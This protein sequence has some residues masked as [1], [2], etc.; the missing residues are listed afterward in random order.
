MSTETRRPDVSLVIEHETVD[1][2]SAERVR[3]VMRLLGEQLRS[4]P[5]S[6]E[7][8]LPRNSDDAADELLGV[9]VRRFDVAPG[10]HYYEV[11]NAGAREARGRV[12]ALADSDVIPRP[13]W[14]VNLVRPFEDPD[15]QV[16]VGNTIVRPT[17]TVASKAFAA[18][19]WF[20]VHERDARRQ[21]LAN[22]VAFRPEVFLPGGFPPNG[23]RYRG[24]EPTLERD[25]AARGI[26]IEVALDARSEHP[27]PAHPVW[28]ALWDG[29]DQHIE[30]RLRGQP[31]AAVLGRVLLHQLLVGSLRI[32]R[33]RRAVGMR[34]TELPWALVLNARESVARAV[35]FLMARFAHDLMHRRVPQ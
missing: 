12:I 19:T 16:A 34:L 5:F 10:A 15:V 27:A 2:V 18:A 28:R 17:P 14:L 26:H 33:H 21:I 4:A 25:W 7:V 31:Y 6:V 3:Q 30:Q 23:C 9:P 11:K 22:N 29:H 13:G 20:P 1:L 35:G 32:V 24:S 8:L